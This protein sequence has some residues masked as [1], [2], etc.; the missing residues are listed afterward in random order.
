MLRP[1]KVPPEEKPFARRARPTPQA[2]RLLFTSM[3]AGV[4][5]LIVLAVVFVPRALDWEGR[6]APRLTLRYEP[7]PPGDPQPARLNVT[8]ASAGVPLDRFAAEILR[9][10]VPEHVRAP[11]EELPFFDDADGD[12]RLTAGDGFAVTVEPGH[13]YVLRLYFEPTGGILAYLAYP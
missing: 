9:D 7:G 2:T 3:M 10:G 8:G 5:L 1:K 11:L 13:A 4:L 12:G 6:Q